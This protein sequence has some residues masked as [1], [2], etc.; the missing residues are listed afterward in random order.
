MYWGSFEQVRKSSA[1]LLGSS[2]KRVGD[3]FN[4]FLCRFKRVVKMAFQQIVVF[5]GTYPRHFEQVLVSLKLGFETFHIN[6]NR[7]V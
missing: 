1:E 3:V 4:P 2:W 6:C 7:V 5:L